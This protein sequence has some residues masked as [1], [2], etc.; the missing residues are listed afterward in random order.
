MRGDVQAVNAIVRII[1]VRARLFGLGA[2]ELGV[3][4]QPQTV[5]VP[6]RAAVP[7]GSR[8]VCIELQAEWGDCTGRQWW[9][10]GSR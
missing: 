9:A 2:E 4:A 1:S 6:L 7:K 10:V 8:V 3:E 5:V